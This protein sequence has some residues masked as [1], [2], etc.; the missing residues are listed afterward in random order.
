M[1]SFSSSDSHAHTALVS[2]PPS[3]PPS[4]SSS[5]P[6]QVL[7]IFKELHADLDLYSNVFGESVLNDAVALV[8]FNT[9][10]TF[11]D[12]P[13]TFSTIATAFLSFCVIF[14]GSVVCCYSKQIEDRGEK[15]RKKEAGSILA[16]PGAVTIAGSKRETKE[17]DGARSFRAP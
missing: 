6:P 10:K 15:V 17:R 14:V 3:L 12:N 11:L 13:V 4:L 5:S 16:R 1:L 9:L 8:L 7:A 2:L